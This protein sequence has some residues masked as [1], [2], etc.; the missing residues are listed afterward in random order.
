MVSLDKGNNVELKRWNGI[1]SSPER[2]KQNS[3]WH[4]RWQGEGETVAY[5]RPDPCKLRRDVQSS[6]NF[7][8]KLANNGTGI[9]ACHEKEDD[10]DDSSGANEKQLQAGRSSLGKTGAAVSGWEAGVIRGVKCRVA[11]DW[12][13]RKELTGPALRRYDNGYDRGVTRPR[14]YNYVGGRPK[15][16]L[17]GRTKPVGSPHLPAPGKSQWRIFG[18]AKPVDTAARERMIEERRS[19]Q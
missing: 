10:I 8:A 3:L 17:A 15:L 4:H 2:R 9:S 11:S 19:R 18:G 1:S 14:S 5:E 16:Q 7:P 13:E 6:R 12:R